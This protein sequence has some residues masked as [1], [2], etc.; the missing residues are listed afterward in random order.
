[1]KKYEL[2]C[3]DADDTL[4]DF[5]RAERYALEKSLQ[6]FGIVYDEAHH[7]RIY[8]QINQAVWREL[9]QGEL[10]QDQL[11]SERFRRLAQALR[12]DFDPVAFGKAYLQALSEA[13]FLL[14]GALEIVR[15]LKEKYRL[16]II[17]NGFHMVQTKRIGESALAPYI[18][19]VVISEDVKSAKPER[20]IFQQALA[21]IGHRDKSTV[22]MV[23]DSLSSD[24]Q[25]G[26]NFAIDTCWFNPTRSENE[27]LIT[28][29]YEIHRLL[30]LK[31][32]V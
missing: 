14:D 6:S 16:L 22:L 2:I 17:T 9:E 31:S 13:S 5:R 3:F 30:E 24:I 4:L 10:A 28:P 20:E 1:M 11:K 21:R 19:E 18:D 32:I 7:L 29:N 27:S 12:Q 8:S 25:G 15:Y 23:G 26:I